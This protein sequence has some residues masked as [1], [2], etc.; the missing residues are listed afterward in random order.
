VQSGTEAGVDVSMGKTLSGHVTRF[1]QLASSLIQPVATM[2]RRPTGDPADREGEGWDGAGIAPGEDPGRH[3]S[4]VYQLQNVGRIRNRGWEMQS[5]ARAGRLAMTGTFSIVDSRVERL[6]VGYAGDL[7][8][9][10]R[11]LAVPRRTMGLTASWS[12]AR[13]YSSWTL[14]RAS[15]WVNYD[16]L[17]IGSALASAG[18]PDGNLLGSW[19]RSHWK[20]YHGVSRLGATL[21]RDLT[22]GLSLMLSGQ[23]L[24]GQQRGEPDNLAIVPGRTITLGIRTRF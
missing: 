5:S 11:M 23:N 17:A 10:D 1:D 22:R 6:A 21:S 14:S 2:E 12:G 20:E 15:D 24:L 3:P 9:G 4:I 16:R 7:R 13:W 8:V 19:L 18:A